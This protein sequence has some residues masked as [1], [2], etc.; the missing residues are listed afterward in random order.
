M[1]DKLPN[2]IDPIYCAS[3]NKRFVASVNQEQFSRLVKQVH[4]AN[5]PVDVEAF[6]SFDKQIKAPVLKL[7]L[8]ADLVL[9]CQRSLEV[10]NLQVKSETLTAFVETMAV[11]EDFPD[12]YEIIEMD[13]EKVSLF[14]LI[15]DEVLLN[16]PM[17]PIKETSEMNYTNTDCPE[18]DLEQEQSNGKTNPFAALKGLKTGN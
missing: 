18:P 7:T 17:V 14:D 6:F 3:N 8:K 5:H 10:F 16:I 12:Q 1:S 11:T 13:E 4:S 2:F 15:E 9:V